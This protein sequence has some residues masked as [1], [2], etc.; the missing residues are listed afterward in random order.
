MALSPWLLA[1][2]ILWPTTAVAESL[3]ADLTSH[4]ISITTGFNGASVV[5]F[6]AVEKPGDIVVTVRGPERT[7]TVRQKSRI[8]GV[9]I[10]TEAVTFVDVPEFYAVAAS[11]PLD[12]IASPA[13]AAHHRLGVDN[14][15]LQTEILTPALVAD[16]FAGALVRGQQRAGLFSDKVGEVVF[17]GDRLFRTTIAIPSNVPTGSYRVDVLLIRNR[18]VIADQTTPLSISK[19]GVDAAVFD[20]ANRRAGLYGAIAVLIAA[21]AGWLASVPFRNA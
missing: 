17:L 15:H 10:N 2:L 4:V 21:A 8:L 20:F 16:V 14:L 11:G 9:W 1:G 12:R 18:E 5:L 6:G 3:A 13:V 7:M 19:V